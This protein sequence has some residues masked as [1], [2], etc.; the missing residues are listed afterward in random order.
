MAAVNKTQLTQVLTNLVL[1]AAHATGNRG[2][3][4][5]TLGQ[6][7]PSAAEAEKLEIAAGAA[8]LTL[9]VA[10]NGTGMDAATVARIFEPFFTTKPLGE[11]TGLG[12]SVVF[13]I[14]RG[15]QGA[16]AVDSTVGTGTVFTLY[17]PLLDQP[18]S[19]AEIA[20]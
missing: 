16:I 2:T 7:R 11:G 6:A 19:P 4:E 20:A 1:N 13:G 5:V 10:D 17:I 12:L 3:I 9:A 15:W 18:T 8:Y 14:L